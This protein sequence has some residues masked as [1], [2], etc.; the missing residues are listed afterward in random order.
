MMYLDGVDFTCTSL[1]NRVEVFNVLGIEAVQAAI[2]KEI[3]NVIEFDGPYIN[4]RSLAHLYNLMTQRGHPPNGNHAVIVRGDCRDFNG[5]RGCWRERQL[6]QIG[7]NVMFGQVAPMV[8]EAFDVALDMDIL[9]D[10]IVDHILP[11]QSMLSAQVDSGMTPGQVAMIPYD[12]NS[13]MWKQ[14]S[15]KGEAAVFSLLASNGDKEAGP[16]GKEVRPAGRT[17]SLSLCSGTSY[18]RC[19]LERSKRQ[20]CHTMC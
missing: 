7:E 20:A 16:K 14:E 11:V 8:T 13:P 18:V 12:S 2:M 19:Q 10:V 5:S 6:P 9:K 1:D 3:C 15:Y 17:N 4:Y